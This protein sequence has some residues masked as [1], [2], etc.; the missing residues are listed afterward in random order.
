M[1]TQPLPPPSQFQK[2]APHFSDVPPPKAIGSHFIRVKYDLSKSVQGLPEM[3]P[4]EL[5]EANAQAGG[6]AWLDDPSEDV[7]EQK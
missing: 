1:N 7:Y 4:D 6:Y 2:I 5:L 3:T